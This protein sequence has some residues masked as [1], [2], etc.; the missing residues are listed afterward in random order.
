MEEEQTIF[1]ELARW[2]MEIAF[3]VEDW[4]EEFDA[5]AGLNLVNQLG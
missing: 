4:D 3:E 1:S 5:D 2:R